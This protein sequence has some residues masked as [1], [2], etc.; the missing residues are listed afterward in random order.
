MAFQAIRASENPTQ[1]VRQFFHANIQRLKKL[2]LLQ[3]FIQVIRV[4]G[5]ILKMTIR[6]NCIE[7][8]RSGGLAATYFVGQAAG[9]A[10]NLWP[11]SLVD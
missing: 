3:G 2:V 11:V 10:G 4:I 6:L 1:R 8:D 7:R 9:C 5:R